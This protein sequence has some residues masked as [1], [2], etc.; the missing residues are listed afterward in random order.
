MFFDISKHRLLTLKEEGY[1]V[2]PSLKDAISQSDISFVCVNTPQ[3]KYSNTINKTDGKSNINYSE[4]N[5]DF[6]LIE[7][8]LGKHQDL[9]QLLSAL[10]D[11]A[12]TLNDN[13]INKRHLLVFR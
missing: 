2:A 7:E 4:I 1:Y 13:I 9:S 11:I 12:M 10:R 5:H 6:D 3:S 8:D